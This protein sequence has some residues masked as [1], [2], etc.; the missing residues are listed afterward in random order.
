MKIVLA[1]V[2]SILLLPIAALCVFGF[3]AIFE[4][5]DRPDVFRAFRIG[6]GVVGVGCLIGVVGLIAKAFRS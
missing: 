4:P 6:Y 5:T 2:A 3:L 1:I